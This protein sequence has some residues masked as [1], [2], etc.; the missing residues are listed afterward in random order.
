M[1]GIIHLIPRRLDWFR[2]NASIP[3]HTALVRY[4]HKRFHFKKVRSTYLFLFKTHAGASILVS[5]RYEGFLC[6]F[7][8]II[9]KRK[10]FISREL[11]TTCLSR[12][13]VTNNFNFRARIG[14]IKNT[15]RLFSTQRPVYQIW[16]KLDNFYFLGPLPTR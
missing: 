3:L 14:K 2:F 5:G 15:P 10:K 11:R 6:C 4:E 13:I 7:R 9:F 1:G 8:E 12:P 16:L